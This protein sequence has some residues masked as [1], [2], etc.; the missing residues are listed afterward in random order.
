MPAH[1]EWKNMQAEIKSRETNCNNARSEIT[2]E[3]ENQTKESVIL[4]WI[5]S[6]DFRGSYQN[7]LER[8]G[9]EEKYSSRC[10]WLINH[11]E[12]EEWSGLGNNS[13]LWL[14]G[15]IGTGKT[16]LMARAIQ[17]IQNTTRI[18]KS[19]VAFYFFQKAADLSTTSSSVET[20]LRSLVR[21]LSW[22]CE[23]QEIEPLVEKKWDVLQAQH[24]GDSPLS[25]GEC[26]KLLKS[27]ISERE[28][29]I[30]IDALDECE[31]QYD[32]MSELTDLSPLVHDNGRGPQALHLMLCGRD[33]FLLSEYFP[34][35]LMIVT[36]STDTSEDQDFYIDQEIDKIC[37]IRRGSILASSPK[38]YS[39]RLKKTLKEKGGG[40][41]RWIEIQLEVFKVKAFKTGDEIEKELHWL[42]SHTKHDTLNK[43]YARL[44]SLNGKP[45]E[46][47]HKSALKML[48]LIA[49]SFYHLSI[50]DLAGA[51]T[52]SSHGPELTPEDVRRIL[53]GFVSETEQSEGSSKLL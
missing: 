7:I 50:N 13:V 1:L 38:A 22:N 32:L 33:D 14:K 25:I 37:Q 15:A 43:E 48:R 26:R 29:Y 41:F 30:M 20:C 10:Q 9:I 40:L 16:T 45:E 12:F 44:M 47:N 11:P 36:N 39:Q 31:K 23:I 52:A 8:T 27:L 5:S 18:E 49:C 42:E 28:T 21:Q 46:M 53:V 35:C 19:G 4:K 24:S 51:M 2:I 34:Q 6:H 3:K 17:E